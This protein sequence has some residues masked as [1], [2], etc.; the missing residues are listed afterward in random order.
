MRRT[1]CT[2]RSNTV[3]LGVS[4]AVPA[5]SRRSAPVDVKKA[6]QLR[7]AKAWPAPDLPAFMI[8]GRALPNGFGLARTPASLKNL[9][10]K[11][12]SSSDQAR[13]TTFHPLLGK[14]VAVRMLP[15][16]HSEHREFT[17]VPARDDVQSEAT[18]PDVVGG[19]KFFGGD[20]RV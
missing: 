2:I 1:C 19:D 8:T 17:F 13:L 3:T 16:L 6:S 4:S 12:N 20:K 9:P 14:L 11:S 7:I 10:S 5:I 15:L 18:F